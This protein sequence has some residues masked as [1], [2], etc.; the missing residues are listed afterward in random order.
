M[1]GGYVGGNMA[2]S[3]RFAA[4]NHIRAEIEHDKLGFIGREFSF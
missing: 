2:L 1:G 4:L 3:N